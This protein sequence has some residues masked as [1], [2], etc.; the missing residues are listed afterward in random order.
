MRDIYFLKL[1]GSLITDKD[2]AHTPRPQ[3]LSRLAAETR[4]ALQQDPNRLVL[5]GHGSGSFGHVP[6]KEFATR[7]GVHRQAQWRGFVEVWHQA[8]EL[9]NLVIQAFHE[10]GLAVLAF[11][12]SAAITTADGQVISWDLHPIEASLK[13]GLLAVIY[14]DVVFDTQRGGTILSTEELFTYLALHIEPCRILLAGMERGV[15]LDYPRCTTL[16]HEITPDNYPEISASLHGSSS[17]DVTGGMLSKVENS[18]ELIK[19]L[20]GLEVAIFSGEEPGN[21]QRALSG[22]P[23][24]TRIRGSTI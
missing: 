11:P 2:Q 19:R 5:L 12:P 13:A 1:G 24:G 8:R 17:T 21:V 18:L 3:V 23:V 6:A 10:V 16:I 7:E 22:E 4:A 20:P 14:G 9:N 15:W